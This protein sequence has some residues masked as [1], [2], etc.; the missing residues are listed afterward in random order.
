MN[1]KPKT[2]RPLLVHGEESIRVGFVITKKQWLALT[3]R[4]R[5]E[6]ISFSDVVRRALDL[7]EEIDWM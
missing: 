1:P 2:G 7:M 3:E 4:A 5:R 6:G